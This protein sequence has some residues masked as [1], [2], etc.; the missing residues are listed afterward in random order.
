MGYALGV[1]AA[2]HLLVAGSGGA[3]PGPS[4]GGTSVEQARPSRR[5]AILLKLKPLDEGTVRRALDLAL[6]MVESPD[7]SQV[8][9]EFQRPDGR[10]PKDELERMG[11]GPELFLESLVFT[12]GSRNPGCRQGGAVMTGTPGS[13]LI[14]VC[15]SFAAFQIGYPRR[16]AATVIHESLHALGLGENPPSSNEITR[17]VERRCWKTPS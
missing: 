2:M 10:T 4:G 16:S 7:C 11:I 15:P 13:A 17:R 3:G 8:Y 12:D 6:A 1:A 9:G 5:R 14:F